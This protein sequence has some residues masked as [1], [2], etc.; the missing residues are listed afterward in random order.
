MALLNYFSGTV[1]N[2][3]GIPG[4]SQRV[5]IPELP[6]TGPVTLNNIKVDN[7]VVGAI[8]T[9]NVHTIDVSLSH[10]HTAGSD[11]AKDALKA[12]TEAILSENKLDNNEKDELLE[13]VA[14]LSSQ[15]TTAAAN[16]KPGLIKATFGAI[17]TAAKTA[18]SVAT[19]WQACEPLLK[20]LFGFP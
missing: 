19:A 12:L 11:V 13:Q 18:T 17:S 1:D 4:F 3:V 7:S 6:S 16:R 20:S 5:Q 10:L 2:V 8:N 9:A 15:A 14:F